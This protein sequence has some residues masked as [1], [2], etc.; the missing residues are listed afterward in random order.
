MAACFGHEPAPFERRRFVEE[1]NTPVIILQDAAELPFQF[2]PRLS[3]RLQFDA[4]P[5]F[6]QRLGTDCDLIFMRHA[7]N[8]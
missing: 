7:S 8:H 4:A 6:R 3:F 2:P 5:K 1:P